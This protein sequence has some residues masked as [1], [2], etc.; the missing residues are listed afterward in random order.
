M[1]FIGGITMEQ[2][3]NDQIITIYNSNDF[4]P[5]KHI[6]EVTMKDKKEYINKKYVEIDFNNFLVFLG[7]MDD[8]RVKNI[9]NTNNFSYLK[10]FATVENNTKKEHIKNTY[11]KIIIKEH[12]IEF[13]KCLNDFNITKETYNMFVNNN[14][15]IFDETFNI[16]IRTVLQYFRNGGLSLI[17]LI[18][19]SNIDQYKID[20]Y[21]V[22][23]NDVMIFG[24]H[25]VDFDKSK[26][27]S[28]LDCYTL[29][30]QHEKQIITTINYYNF[31]KNKID[32]SLNGFNMDIL[33]NILAYVD[34]T[35]TLLKLSS[36]R[37]I[38]IVDKQINNNIYDV[39]VKD[40]MEKHL[41]YPHG[42]KCDICNNYNFS[43]TIGNK[44]NYCNETEEN[45]LIV[46]DSI[47]LVRCIGCNITDVCVGNIFVNNT[48][49]CGDCLDTKVYYKSNTPAR[50]W[51][52]CGTCDCHFFV[53]KDYKG[54]DAKCLLH[55][56]KTKRVY[57]P[58]F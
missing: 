36:L 16:E 42:L 53:K 20:K 41:A 3:T 54:I 23:K 35:N 38:K 13:D 48:V 58:W 44:C 51:A 19:S 24:Y 31:Q 46:S 15:N 47:Q 56:H 39:V 12:N 10:K 14:Y 34:D 32:E 17:S 30:T 33:N 27:F 50:N 26:E 11:D 37:D 29:L 18:T 25:N 8:E 55:R 45:K 57:N 43:I 1:G 49:Y 21:L 5:L 22:N 40:V 52:R 4:R 6:K 9:H 28:K 7:K 2:I